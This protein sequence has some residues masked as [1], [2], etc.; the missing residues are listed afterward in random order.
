VI[1]DGDGNES[2]PGTAT[3]TVTAAAK[4]GIAK[5]LVSITKD[6]SG[7]FNLTYL[8][9]LVNYGDIAV[10]RVSLTDNLA[11]AFPDATYQIISINTSGNLQVNTNYNGSTVLNMLLPGST[12]EAK[13]KRQVEMQ[14]KVTVNKD[15]S[16]FNNFAVAEGF[17]ADNGALTS[18]QSTN[19]FNPDPVTAG[20][21][22]P[23]ELTPVELIKGTLKIPAGFSPNNDGINDYFVV[24]N[25]QGQK[26]SLEIFN[27]WGNRIYRS[28]DYKNDWA[29]KS[30]EGIRVGDDVPVGTYYYV[31]IIDGK[32]KR[33]G[34]IT[35][36]R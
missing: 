26:V 28:A 15:R 22:R 4:I 29:G 13:S 23:S 27:R 17:S 9:T 20:D 11:L 6:I 2:Q 33:V 35:I 25:T 18:D 31:I 36:N 30:T 21:V 1:R 34:Y 19:G 7:S 14:I 3:I 16:T 8:F 12:L 5:A 24:E 10:E 32:D